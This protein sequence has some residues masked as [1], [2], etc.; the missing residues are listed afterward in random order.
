M[1][2]FKNYLLV[3]ITLSI[4]IYSQTMINVEIKQKLNDGSTDIGVLK[5]W[6][7][8][9]WSNS[10]SP[11]TSFPFAVN[12]IQVLLGDQNIYSSQK[13]NN[14][15]NYVQ[16]VTNFHHCEITETTESLTSHFEET[17]TGIIIRNSLE[18]TSLS[19]DSNIHV[20]FKDPWYIDYPDPL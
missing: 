11:G 13:Y 12:S 6:E 4:S 8:P 16:D 5:K 9:T 15:N 20:K 19:F 17:H 10:F 3:L 18:G 2:S 14:W 1:K 7:Y